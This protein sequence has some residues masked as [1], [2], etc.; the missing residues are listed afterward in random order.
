MRTS[1][2]ATRTNVSS[3]RDN[4]MPTGR[5][6]KIMQKYV[7]TSSPSSIAQSMSDNAAQ[8]GEEVSDYGVVLDLP[9]IHFHERRTI[10]FARPD[11][12]VIAVD[13]VID[14]RQGAKCAATPMFLQ[15]GRDGC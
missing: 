6:T 11:V 1:L 3:G 12:L 10:R 9:Q 5:A 15:D 2:G 4:L 13:E 7:D 14:D 8:I